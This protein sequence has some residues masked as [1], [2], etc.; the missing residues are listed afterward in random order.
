M[1]KNHLIII[2]IIMIAVIAAAIVLNNQPPAVIHPSGPMTGGHEQI[3]PY[4]ATLTATQM[5]EMIY[6][7]LY[8][9]CVGEKMV[10]IDDPIK[11]EYENGTTLHHWIYTCEKAELN[12]SPSTP[13]CTNP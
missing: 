2:T 12:R 9:E 7:A 10:F 3:Q 6:V 5:D 13:I 4:P 8:P 1:N 11:I